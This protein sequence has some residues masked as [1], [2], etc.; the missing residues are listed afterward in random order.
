MSII[1]GAG[2]NAF[3]SQFTAGT[4]YALAEIIDNSIQW[5][6]PEKDCEINIILIE[7][8]PSWW[9]RE[10]II[11]DNGIGMDEDTLL[12]CLDFGGGKNHSYTVDGQLGKFGLGLPYSSCS[13]SPNYHVYSWQKKGDYKH[14]YRNH[15]EYQPYQPVERNKVSKLSEL[16]K[17]ITDAYPQLVSQESGTVVY[18]KDCDK[19]DVKQSKTLIK[20]IEENLGRIYRH[21][22]NRGVNINFIVYKD[23]GDK[24]QKDHSI[25]RPIRVFDPLFLM[26]N[27]CLPGDAGKI[28]TSQI[29]GGK[30]GTGEEIIEFEEK[31]DDGDI[32]KH[33]IKLRYSIAKIETQKPGGS[34]DGGGNDI[35]QYYKKATG[36]SLVRENRELKLDNFGFQFPNSNEV[37]NRWWS[38]EVSFK[39]IS[40]EIL[41]VNANK[42]DAKNF[43]YLSSEDKLEIEKDGVLDPTSELRAILS[44]RIE[45]SYNSM[46]KEIKA[47][48]K[49]QRT[50]YKCPAQNCGQNTF[51]SGICSSCGYTS[52]HCTIHTDEPLNSL[53]DCPICAKFRPLDMC[54]FHKIPMNKDGCPKCQTKRPPLKESEKQELISLLEDYKEFENNPNAIERTINWFQQSNNNHFMVFTDLKN[55]AT[56]IDHHSFQGDKFVIIEVNISHPFYDQFFSKILEDN[57]NNNI[58]PLLL[59]IASWVDT[60]MNDYSNTD[61]LTRFRTKF[62]VN[63]MDIIANWSKK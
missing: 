33:E 61:T 51:S 59:F 37:I 22:I 60:E 27:T 1:N 15:N 6:T 10:I 57:D 28:P 50:V 54:I 43:R 32:V 16:P 21:F 3:R 42:L 38:I 23:F 4:T 9:L 46:Y 11:S 30:N 49:G 2:L 29:W 17:K 5:K 58:T 56:F 53:G 14:T 52:N 41:G 40:D 24:L 45:D 62:G 63:L 55:P 35:G 39:R 8:Q 31:S 18:W 7:S 34:S 26:E 19:L 13:Q 25:S 47:R 48:G 12:S 20:H 44:R 36:I